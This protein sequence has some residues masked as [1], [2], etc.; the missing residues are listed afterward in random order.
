MAFMLQ[1]TQTPPPPKGILAGGRFM[2]SS[3]TWLATCERALQPCAGVSE[4]HT[5]QKL[6]AIG[7]HHCTIANPL[8][9]RGMHNP[10]IASKPRR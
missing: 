4:G 6:C 2:V 1:T 10:S 5:A 3:P 8:C 9:T 7:L